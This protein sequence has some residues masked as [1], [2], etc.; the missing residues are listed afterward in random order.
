[1][2]I[3]GLPHLQNVQTCSGVHPVSYLMNFGV[4]CPEIKWL[5]LEVNKLTSLSAEIKNE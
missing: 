1:V 3:R 5:G 2:E 4:Y